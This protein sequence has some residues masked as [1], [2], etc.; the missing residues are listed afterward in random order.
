MQEDGP[1]GI[2]KA[3]ICRK[4]EIN[5]FFYQ[6]NEIIEFTF[7]ESHN[8]AVWTTNWMQNKE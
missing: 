3:Q 2:H 5:L 4:Q 1:K 8:R 6:E 7:S